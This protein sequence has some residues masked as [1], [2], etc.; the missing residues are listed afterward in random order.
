MLVDWPW[1]NIGN[2]DLD[3]G[4]IAVDALIQDGQLTEQQV[5]ELMPTHRGPRLEFLH[6][7]TVALAGYYLY[8]SMQKPSTSTNTGLIEMR[9]HRALALLDRLFG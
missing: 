6:G 1:A 5:L 3:L 8:T 9:A 2:A 7:C 4:L